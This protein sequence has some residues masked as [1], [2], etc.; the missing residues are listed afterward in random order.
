MDCIFDFFLVPVNAYR[1][2]FNDNRV[3]CVVVVY[4]AI[5]RSNYTAKQGCEANFNKILCA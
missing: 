4:D 3:P 1:E 5:H 2:Y